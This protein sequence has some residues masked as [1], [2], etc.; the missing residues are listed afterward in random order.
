MLREEKFRALSWTVIREADLD[1]GR[2]VE[3]R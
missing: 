3:D 2:A 1:W